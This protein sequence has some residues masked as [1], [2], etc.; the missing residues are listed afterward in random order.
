M[1]VCESL[2]SCMLHILRRKKIYIMQSLYHITYGI[3]VNEFE[4]NAHCP[5]MY[6]FLVSQTLRRRRHFTCGRWK[7]WV[8]SLRPPHFHLRGLR[9]AADSAMT[10]ASATC[11][12]FIFLRYDLL[13]MKAFTFCALLIIYVYME[14]RT[15]NI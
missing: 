9:A 4:N 12:A 5:M 7:R 15:C 1:L 13:Y 10:N 6:V 8:E 11:M 3:M 14:I 2:L